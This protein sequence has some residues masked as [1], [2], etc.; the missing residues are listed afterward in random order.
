MKARKEAAPPPVKELPEMNEL[1]PLSIL[2]LD[3]PAPGNG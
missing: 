1:I 2:E 3:L